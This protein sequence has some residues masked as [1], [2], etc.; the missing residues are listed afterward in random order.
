MKQIKPVLKKL[1]RSMQFFNEIDRTEYIRMDGNE[2]VDGLPESFVRSVLNKVTPA[3]LASYPNPKNCTESVARY[4]GVDRESVF[5][6]NGSD[7]AIKMLF[8]VFVEAGDKVVIASP[9][10]EMYEVYCNMFGAIAVNKYYSDGFV[11]PLQ[12]YIS[13]IEK[14]AK[15]AIITNP[16]NPTG[17]VIDEQTVKRILDVAKRNDTLVMVDEAYYWIYNESMIHLLSEYP[18]MVILRT[19]S[20]LLGVAGLRLG[21]AV[22]GRDLIQDMKKVAPPAGVNAIALLFGEEIINSPDLIDCL[23]HNFKTEKEYFKIQME[24]NN[25]DY[26]DTESNYFLIPA[27]ENYRTVQQKMKDE[28]ILIAYKMGKYYR[29]NV[30]NKETVD[31][32]VSAFCRYT[33]ETS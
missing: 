14:G 7:A 22:G 20:K 16:N 21:F 12:E 17:T 19:F 5:L 26:I 11:F 1:Y 2:S 18:N 24:L 25:I 27:G 13:E 32:F 9:A 15:L 8:E 4:L 33:S 29:V 30:G 6:T 31:R 23:V 10:F 3:I 28:G